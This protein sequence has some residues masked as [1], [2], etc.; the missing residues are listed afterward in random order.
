MNDRTRPPLTQALP[1]E[2]QHHIDAWLAAV[3]AQTATLGLVAG[4]ESC[5]CH[6]ADSDIPGGVLSARILEG[7]CPR[8]GEVQALIA[9][10]RGSSPRL[11]CLRCPVS[12]GDSVTFQV[13]FSAQGDGAS[14]GAR[15]TSLAAPL[16]LWARS[17]LASHLSEDSLH[18]EL[19]HALGAQDEEREWIALEVHDRIAQTLAS[20]FQQLQ[21]LEGLARSFPEMRQ[22]AVRA[23]LL[24]REAIREAR[25]IMNDLRPPVLDHLGLVPAMKEELQQ[26]AERLHCHVTETF[27]LTERLPRGTEIT[28]YR[29]FR[30]ALTNIQ[31]HAQAK[32]VRVALREDTG[33]VSLEVSDNGAGFHVRDAIGR[34]AVVGLLSMK[35]RAQAIGG[36]CQI[37]SE[38]GHGTRITVRLPL[39]PLLPVGA[40][41]HQGHHP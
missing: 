19:S 25:N 9:A 36:T 34:K 18:A 35:R 31:R 27:S 40:G 15:L 32:E 13:G 11:L 4:A 24:C 5:T 6:A 7:A 37:Q 3:A 29:I 23:S 30:E 12:N 2:M 21:T 8:S 20:V 22:A 39:S 17:L 26:M 16:L 28:L 33:G 38:P 1:A 41:Q 10:G 14:E